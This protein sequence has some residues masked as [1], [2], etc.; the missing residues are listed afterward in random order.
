MH[1]PG[2]NRYPGRGSPTFTFDRSIISRLDQIR[3]PSVIGTGVQGAEKKLDEGESMP[4]GYKVVITV[5]RM[6]FKVTRLAFLQ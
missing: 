2:L 3:K 4:W 5:L 6:N 1:S